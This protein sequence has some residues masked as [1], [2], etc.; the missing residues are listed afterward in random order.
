MNEMG[1]KIMCARRAHNMTQE[2]L[3]K[4][5][6]CN[7]ITIHRLET[8]GNVAYKLVEKVCNVLDLEI[9]FR[10]KSV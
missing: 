5:V 1:I 6:G 8:K 2:E 7:H 3:A 9:I 4:L 10:K